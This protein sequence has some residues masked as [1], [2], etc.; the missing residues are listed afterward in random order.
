MKKKHKQVILATATMPLLV[1]GLVLPMGNGSIVQKV[2]AEGTAS[3]ANENY[4]D[5]ESFWQ[6]KYNPWGIHFLT[7]DGNTYQEEYYDGEKMVKRPASSKT[8]LQAKFLETA[9]GKIF[10]YKHL[11]AEAEKLDGVFNP[12]TNEFTTF[13]EGG[14]HPFF[15]QIGTKYQI[16]FMGEVNG[17]IVATGGYAPNTVYSI[18]KDDGKTWTN[19]SDSMKQLGY[20]RDMKMKDG[21]MV[22]QR[23]SGGK[24]IVSS[25]TD[26]VNWKD[27]Y[28]L[29]SAYMQIFESNGRITALHGTNVYT[30]FDDGKTF[31]QQVRNQSLVNGIV[32]LDG[33]FVGFNRDVFYYSEDGINWKVSPKTVNNVKQ[34]VV[35]EENKRFIAR[36]GDFVSVSK[37]GENWVNLDMNISNEVLFLNFSAPYEPSKI[38]GTN[39]PLKTLNDSLPL[40]EKLWDVGEH[41]MLTHYG[42][43]TNPPPEMKW[44]HPNSSS[45]KN[46]YIRMNGKLID[47]NSSNYTIDVYKQEVNP[48]NPNT[49]TKTYQGGTAKNNW[50]D[51]K[52][53]KDGRI[54][55]PFKSSF[56]GASTGV[57]FYD[58]EELSNVSGRKI[59]EPESVIPFT[60]DQMTPTIAFEG[61]GFIGVVGLK[62]ENYSNASAVVSISHDGGKTWEKSN[63]MSGRFNNVVIEETGRIVLFGDTSWASGYQA[64]AVSDDGGKTFKNVQGIKKNDTSYTPLHRS[65]NHSVAYRDGVYIW[66]F[67]NTYTSTDLVNWN[68][69]KIVGQLGTVARSEFVKYDP[70]H[71]AFL[72]SAE[73]YLGLSRDGIHWREVLIRDR[74]DL[75]VYENRLI[76]NDVHFTSDEIS[77]NGYPKHEWQGG[78]STTK[79]EIAPTASVSIGSEDWTSRHA[80]ISVSDIKDEGQGFDY[81]ILP[82]GTISK[83][84]NINFV[85]TENGS[86]SFK[87]YD[88]AGNMQEYVMDVKSIDKTPATI[89]VES[90]TTE[91]TKSDVELSV[92]AKDS[93]SGV[94]HILL[95][96]G[97]KVEGDTAKFNAS[98]NG[99]YAFK[100][101]DKAGNESEYRYEVNNID[102]EVGK[103]TLV[104]EATGWTNE[105]TTIQVEATDSGSGVDY[106]ITPSGKKVVS[107]SFEFQA[108]ENG[109]YTFTTVDKAGNEWKESITVSNIDRTVGTG[110][111]TPSTTKST[112]AKFGVV[113]TAEGSDKESGMAYVIL[114]SGV[115]VSGDKADYTVHANGDYTFVFIDGAGNSWTETIAVSNLKGNA[116]R[117]QQDP[118]SEQILLPNGKVWKGKAPQT[119][120][121]LLKK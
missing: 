89:E 73:N 118:S 60:P 47:A 72:V 43:L 9:S 19:M 59:V 71:D 61:D 16:S 75:A 91:W 52:L 21:K 55:V 31:T 24:T 76:F 12:E 44:N 106:V 116:Y 77:K 101:V 110:K 83:E 39:T 103:T 119:P 10:K 64:I 46:I 94:S 4:K 27:E 114:P 5:G 90:S 54:M 26:G 86:Y 78:S 32:H 40:G 74:Q 109:V 81:M 48:F 97:E 87:L 58:A 102:R 34:I 68:P 51:V 50:A 79:D 105:Y 3:L 11:G 117:A 15:F 108:E 99:E 85:V 96:T 38:Q 92:V 2:K 69:V 25:S 62:N 23:D 107:E 7:R 65:S 82:D 95:P 120:P 111:V 57:A 13:H 84:S 37:D 113:L 80:T 56:K 93:E 70:V 121:G 30:S 112:N 14:N 28:T 29:P 18:S 22:I 1:S 63:E 100:A 115:V 6:D 104:N 33:K 42:W 67:G 45:P 66:S 49:I 53:L 20:I 8:M 36:G 41:Y 88:K 17:T 35:D 98:E